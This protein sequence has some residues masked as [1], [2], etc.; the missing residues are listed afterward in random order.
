MVGRARRDGIEDEIAADLE[1][2]KEGTRDRFSLARRCVRLPR[3]ADPLDLYPAFRRISTALQS[4][5]QSAASTV[6]QR[7]V[8]CPAIKAL[9]SCSPRLLSFSIQSS[10][11][12][13]KSVG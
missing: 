10:L 6:L 13:E 2:G 12:A 3:F 11:M 9:I 4:K 8:A 7:C 5:V 1:L